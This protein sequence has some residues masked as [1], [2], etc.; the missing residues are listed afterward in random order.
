MKFTELN[1]DNFLLFAIK[2]YDNPQ[3]STKDEFFEDLQRFKYIKRLMKRYSK[4]GD[5]K[6]HLLLN[7]V[8][9]VYNLFGDAGTPI[10]FYKLERTYWSILKTILIFLNRLEE[11]SIT[12]IPID[13]ICK[14][15]L[16]K[17]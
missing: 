11:D 4:T 17:L 14:Q 15:E 12:D 13:I 7:H 8:I 6:I 5:L 1:E 16:D 3:C 9:I 2:N 10:L